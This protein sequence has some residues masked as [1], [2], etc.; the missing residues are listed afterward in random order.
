MGF[1]ICPLI[2]SVL[3]GGNRKLPSLKRNPPR[4]LRVTWTD[5]IEASYQ[6]GCSSHH[7]TMVLQLWRKYAYVNRRRCE[8]VQQHNHNKGKRLEVVINQCVFDQLVFWCIL[9]PSVF[10]PWQRSVTVD[11]GARV[12]NRKQQSGKVDRPPDTRPILN[13]C[14]W[15]V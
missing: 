9:I 7:V 6:Q 10:R 12:S 2:I 13:I 1:K 11:G 14:H 3:C 15:L 4:R 5:A 8:S